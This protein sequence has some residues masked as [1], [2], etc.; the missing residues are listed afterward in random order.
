MTAGQKILLAIQIICMVLSA[1][2]TLSLVWESKLDSGKGWYS[3][4]SD[5]DWPIEKP[6]T[7]LALTIAFVTMLIV[8]SVLWPI[9][10]ILY[11]ENGVHKRRK[12]L[13]R[14]SFDY[15]FYYLSPRRSSL[16]AK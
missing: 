7:A 14:N 6:T 13:G 12:Q 15:L 4:L 3:S 10:I 9:A 2:Y 1:G 8:F 16:K 5:N 11:Y